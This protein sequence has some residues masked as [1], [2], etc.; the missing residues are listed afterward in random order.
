MRG[1][2]IGE[3]ERES[4]GGEHKNR[5]QSLHIYSIPSFPLL[6]FHSGVE[7]SRWWLASRV[8]P[9][10]P[11]SAMTG[12]GAASRAPRPPTDAER[13]RDVLTRLGPA[14]IKV[15]QALSSR[16]DLMPPA[17]V[18]ALEMLQDRIP[19][20]PDADARAVIEGEL[21]MA[22]EAVFASLSPTP[23]A[24]ASLGQVYR[25][26][27]RP[28][29]GGG[30]VAV[31]VQRPGVR[32]SIALD[33]HIVR[34]VAGALRAARNVNTD[35]AALVDEWAASL[36][37]ELDYSEEADNGVRFKRLYGGL[38]GVFVPD[39]RVDLT[40]RRV[41]VMEW[42][43][44]TR[45]RSAGGFGGASPTSPRKGG[46]AA[47]ADA[48]SAAEDLR[49]VDI[50]VRCSLEQM[51]EEGFYH[52]DPHP[53]NLLKTKDG[54][55]AY[56][57]FGMMGTV[58]ATVRAALITAC[59]HLVNREFAA[60]ADDF[61]ALGLLPAGSAK[62]DIAPALT[63][64]FSGALSRGVSQVSFSNLSAD[65]GQTMYAY[66]F[67]I[68]PYYTLLVRSLSVLEGIALAADP[69]YK[70]LGAAYPWIAR[71]LLAGPSPALRDSLRAVLYSGGSFQFERLESLLL[72]AARS[73]PRPRPSTPEGG[74]RAA[75]R[76]GGRGGGPGASTAAA[77]GA[78]SSPLALLLGPDGGFIR[79]ILVEELAKGLDGA[80][81]IGADA[82]AD[83]GAA[84]ASAVVGAANAAGPG[85][86]LAL[87]PALLPA[88][89]A[90]ALLG[91]LPRTARPADRE[92][93]D[94]VARLARALREL[95]TVAAAT[96][97]GKGAA[98][99][100]PV[101]F[102]ASLISAPAAALAAAVAAAPSA[103][104][105]PGA[106]TA[107]AALAWLASEVAT[108]P[109]AAAATAVALPAEV[110]AAAASVG[111]ARALRAAADLD[112]SAAGTGGAGAVQA[113][114]PGPAPQR[115]AAAAAAAAPAPASG[116]KPRPQAPRRTPTPA[117]VAAAAAPRVARAPAPPTAPRPVNGSARV[118]GVVLTSGAVATSK[119]SDGKEV[120]MVELAVPP[121]MVG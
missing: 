64:V 23:V 15:G 72:Q 97:G 118:N 53:G 28:E 99:A 92:Q 80:V 114:S 16:P 39:M 69:Q 46:P 100:Q 45:L 119:A 44:G 13:M 81:R 32:A 112:P 106:A 62:D 6:M 105:P 9:T 109:P 10:S 104:V 57:D 58:D 110:L 65:L 74:D 70:V 55:L 76:E 36:F 51:L 20:F 40:T 50:G 42:V 121:G 41:L 75:A 49:L 25:G 73:P 78:A 84:A 87:G 33:I 66:Q 113:S 29:Y 91:S 48:A 88:R 82:A 27:L 89:A 34:R 96:A 8:S 107:T 83:A 94:G 115:K 71:R 102:P 93:V 116:P 98:P 47:D 85:A 35:L 24:A 79:E 108:L 1:I 63:A 7:F 30:E 22:P 56:I 111:A 52:S 43:D 5:P 3:G 103:L 86:A 54:R 11:P 21:G 4:N 17:Y 120:V 14:F 61:V 19:P 60:L 59:L 37:R 101:S 68:P 38:E 26:T 77:G 2:E 67:R 12:S 95:S 90:V 117:P 18:A 31:K